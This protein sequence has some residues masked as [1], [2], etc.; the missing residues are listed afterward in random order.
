[1]SKI[2]PPPNPVTPVVAPPTAGP[3]MSSS[4]PAGMGKLTMLTEQIKESSSSSEKL[5][6]TGNKTAETTADNTGKQVKLFTDFFK[7][8]KSKEGK[9]QELERELKDAISKLGKGGDDDKKK[10]EEKE[11]DKDANKFKLFGLTF[12]ATLK[13]I[14]QGLGGFFKGISKAIRGYFKGS[15]SVVKFIGKPFVTFFKGMGTRINKLFKKF[16]PRRIRARL[17]LFV[18]QFTKAVTAIKNTLK[19]FGAGIALAGKNVKKSFGRL[20]AKFN[21]FTKANNALKAFEQTNKMNLKNSKKPN[22]K[23][24]ALKDSKAFK[25]QGFATKG[26]MKLKNA[27]RN[28]VPNAK[29][30]KGLGTFAKLGKNLLKGIPIIGQIITIIEGVFGAFKGFFKYKDE[31]FLMGLAGGFIGFFRG[32]AVGLFGFLGDFIKAI[33]SKIFKILLGEDNKISAILDSFSFT[34]MINTFFDNI[35]NGIGNFFASFKDGFDKG[36]L[37]GITNLGL[38]ILK[39]IGKIIKFPIALIAGGVAALLNIFGDPAEAFGKTYR[40]VMDVGDAS[41]EKAKKGLGVTSTDDIEKTRKQMRQ[42][43]KRIRD[44]EKAQK[45]ADKAAKK[46]A[47][48][49]EKEALRREQEALNNSSGN[50][51]NFNPQG[52]GSGNTVVAMDNSNNSRGGDSTVVHNHY[53]SGGGG[54]AASATNKPVS[55]FGFTGMA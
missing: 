41:I 9:Q 52:N 31:G 8:I 47:D 42:E 21:P 49:E 43:A 30:T 39:F 50:A 36:I 54:D 29:V 53:Y 16:V 33:P 20:N 34:D 48:R 35:M 13:A 27:V 4:E 5:Q 25:A 18:R 38:E 6:T 3:T 55:Q 17:R 46:K 14:S 7:D 28:A 44:E 40:K 22:F 26:I 10:D 2:P 32:I 19:G 51:D 11:K 45:K 12:L 37:V 23:P 15:F 24:T 1:M